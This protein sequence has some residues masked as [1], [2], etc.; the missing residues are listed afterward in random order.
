MVNS[1]I[2]IQIGARL[3]EARS[4]AG[5]K[6]SASFADALGI[7]KPTY[8][9][10][11]NGN[12]AMSIETI[13]QYAEHLKVSWEYLVTGDKTQNVQQQNTENYILDKELFEKVLVS[14]E[15]IFVEQNLQMNNIEKANLVY[16][17]YT[18][19]HN[20]NNENSRFSIKDIKMCASGIIMYNNSKNRH[21]TLQV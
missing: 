4:K 20:R 18:S 3:R 21:F 10:H 6:T 2:Y 7:N 5:Y 14:I 13:M 11:E 15:E 19:V 9:N 12:R 16:A 8:S 1:D 17:V